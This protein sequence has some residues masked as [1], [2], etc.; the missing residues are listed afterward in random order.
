MRSVAVIINARLSSTRLPQKLVK[1][2][3][4]TC[5]IRLAL[6]KL[7]QVNVP[8]RYLATRDDA[9]LEIYKPFADR[10]ELLPRTPESVAPS[11]DKPDFRVVFS[12]YNLI[13]DDYVLAMNPCFPFVRP[14]TIES[15]AK[16]FVE[17]PECRTMTSVT[18]SNNVFFDDSGKPINLL[19][20]D[21]ASTRWNKYIY[22]M[23][24]VFHIFDRKQLM[25]T[26]SIWDYTPENPRLYEVDPAECFDVDDPPDFDLCERLYR[27]GYKIVGRVPQPSYSTASGARD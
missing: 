24:H 5:L 21:N 17:H 27:T 22:E 18:R 2:L 20:A 4:D 26:G 12:H 25:Q 14:E 11:A 6:E 9:I 19:H 23:A 16:F 8:H 7:Y 1:P 3:G 15:A 10:I 13:P